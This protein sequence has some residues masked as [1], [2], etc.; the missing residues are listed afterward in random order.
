MAAPTRGSST[1][2]SQVHVVWAALVG[3]F[4]GGADIQSYLLEWDG[5]SA[6][7]SWQAL[8][9]GAGA[10][11]TAT[12]YI[13]NPVDS[14]GAIQAGQSYRFRV[15]ARNAHGWSTVSPSVTITAATVPGPA[16]APTTSVENIYVKLAWTPPVDNNAA[17]DG[18]DVYIANATGHFLKE[19]VYC[20]GFTNAVVRQSAYCLVPM[21]VLTAAPY[22]LPRGAPV[23]AKVQAH[24]A[25]GYGDLSP[26][27]AAGGVLAQTPPG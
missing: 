12:Q 8:L 10:E 27:S 26:Q 4:T 19:A 2:T 5:G 1:T 6:G 3:A 13:I 25:Y 22:S 20:D 17:I 21:S 18:Y 15:S 16:T 9:G 14:P 7:A 11:S 23:L 24:N